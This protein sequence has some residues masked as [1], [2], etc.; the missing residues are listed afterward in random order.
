VISRLDVRAR[1][2]VDLLESHADEVAGL[3]EDRA[4]ELLELLAERLA[5]RARRGQRRQ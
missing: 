2:F 5:D 1:R 4:E 3:V